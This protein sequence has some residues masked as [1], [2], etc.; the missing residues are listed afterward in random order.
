MITHYI[1]LLFL[2]VDRI[3]ILNSTTKALIH[4]IITLIINKVTQSLNTLAV[5]PAYKANPIEL[6]MKSY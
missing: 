1:H 5:I 6:I 4:Y 2:Y 3:K